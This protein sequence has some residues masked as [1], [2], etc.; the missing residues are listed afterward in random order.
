MYINLSYC[1]LTSSE[2]YFSSVQRKISI[3][4]ILQY[5]RNLMCTTCYLHYDSVHI[6]CI[7]LF[8]KICMT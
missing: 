1:Y 3:K 5:A 2:L 6:L 4:Y 7:T 8:S